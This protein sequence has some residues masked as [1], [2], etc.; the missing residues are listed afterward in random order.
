MTTGIIKSS[1]G[2][3]SQ[4]LQC[5][6]C[7]ILVTSP[8]ILQH[9]VPA[10]SFPLEKSWLHPRNMLSFKACCH[11]NH[12]QELKSW[13]TETWRLSHR[14]TND[15]W[16]HNKSTADSL[17]TLKCHTCLVKRD[18]KSAYSMRFYSTID[19]PHNIHGHGALV[20]LGYKPSIH[21]SMG[22]LKER[23]QLLSNSF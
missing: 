19:N 4:S 9:T 22:I 16:S 14:Q 20:D 5:T 2:R 7:N 17:A 23:Y 3:G 10:T 8:L 1:C 21:I 12:N 6:N 15:K 11:S 13:T 18:N